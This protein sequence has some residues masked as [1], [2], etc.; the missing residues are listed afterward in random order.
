M[1][2]PGAERRVH[3][4]DPHQITGDRPVGPEQMQGGHRGKPPQDHDEGRER[5]DRAQHVDADVHRAVDEQPDV[6]GNALV[7]VVGD[8][9]QELHAIMVGAVEP[10]AE[11][12]DRHPPPPAD[13]QPLI[14]IELINR[15]HDEHR[16]EHAEIL[17]LAH[18]RIPIVILDRVEEP[19]VPLVDEHLDRHEAELDA[20]HAREQDAP[21]PA[22]LG[23]KVG[24]SQAPDGAERGEKASH[25]LL[26]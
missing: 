16:R 15:E 10:V 14:E 12:P 7:R 19:R 18:E 9:A 1:R 8:V 25:G 23:T 6:L 13:L 22:V 21:R 26:L 11:I 24:Q 2:E 5:H 3:E 4:R 17:E 20:D